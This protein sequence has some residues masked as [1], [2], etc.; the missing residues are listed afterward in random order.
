MLLPFDYIVKKY[1]I[2]P[3]G[4]L[5]IGA[6]IGEEAKAYD[7]QGVK[8]VCWIE[9]NPELIPTLRANVKQYGHKVVPALVGDMEDFEVTFH[10][11]NNAGQSS[12]YLELGTHKKVHPS[13][14]YVKDITM[15]TRRLDQM[16]CWGGYDFLNIDIQGAELKALKGMGETLDHFK[17][18]YLEVNWKELYIGCALFDEVERFLTEKGF[19]FVESKESGK[20]GW[21]DALFIRR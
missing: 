11:S 15:K 12:S 10:I 1:N 8:D 21:G 18:V 2:K 14:H 6:N 16:S 9:A 3:I 17:W 7:L 4:I 13:V 20:T 19:K 5:H